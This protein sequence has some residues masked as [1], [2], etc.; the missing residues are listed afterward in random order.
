MSAR[1]IEVDFVAYNQ[2]GH[3]FLLVEVKAGRKETSETWA[4]QFRR[5]LLAHGTLPKAPYFLIATPDRMYFWHQ[6]DVSVT[7]K[8]P[9]FSADARVELQS[10]FETANQDSTNIG[11]PA[12]TLILWAW[13]TE[14]AE[15]GTN[16]V[17]EPSLARWL[18]ESGLLRELRGA[19]IEMPTVQ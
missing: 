5:N 10:Y 16:R 19:R 17:K 3:P 1:P 2:Q 9:D 11:G 14:I 18:F 6:N 13:L 7:E 15:F 8:R 4:A 12:F